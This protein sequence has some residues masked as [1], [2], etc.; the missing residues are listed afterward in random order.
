MC[1]RLLIN[2]GIA[3]VI[4]RLTMND[5]KTINVEKW[6]EDDE[7]LFGSEGY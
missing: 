2:S 1:K 5:F 7:S 6:I 4:V 3:K